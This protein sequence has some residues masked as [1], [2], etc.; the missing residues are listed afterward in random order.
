MGLKERE[1]NGA[2]STTSRTHGHPTSTFKT[3]NC[4][5]DKAF[6]NTRVGGGEGFDFRKMS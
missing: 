2:A 6:P 3:D 4:E 1:E 5:S